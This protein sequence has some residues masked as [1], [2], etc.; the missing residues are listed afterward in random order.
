MAPILPILFAAVG[1]GLSRRPKLQGRWLTGALIGATLLSFVLYSPAPLGRKYEPY[2][3]EVGQRQE[4]A[5]DIV[6]SIPDDAK[7]VAQAAFTIQLAQREYIYLYPWS[8]IPEEEIDYLIL[9]E[10]FNAYPFAISE[11]HWEILNTVANPDYVVEMEANG[12]YLFHRGGEPLPSMPVD[13]VAEDAIRLEK[14]EVAVANERGVFH[15]VDEQPL[16]L[17]PGQEIRVT[18]YWEALAAPNAERTVSVRIADATGAL[19]AQKDEQPSEASRPTSW[20]EPGW[21]F[22]DVNT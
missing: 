10:N 15:T 9:G 18:L 11:I 7:V 20:W 1:I 14:V 13:R 21:Y 17:A 3:Y 8:N 5:W 4:V 12:V 19:V 2:R 6:E 22:R 16:T